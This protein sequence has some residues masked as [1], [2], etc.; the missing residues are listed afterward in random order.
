MKL[1]TRPVVVAV[2]GVIV[3]IAAAWFLFRP[4][5]EETCFDRLGGPG[6]N[7]NTS[8]LDTFIDIPVGQWPEV[9]QILEQF[10]TER[11]WSVQE[12][13][14]NTDPDYHW[15]DM[16]DAGVT[17]VRASNEQGEPPNQVGFGIIHMA[18]EGPARDGW[19]PYYR[20]L[21]RRL[22][23][24]WPGKLRYVEGE[25]GQTITRPLWLD[26]PGSAPAEAPAP[27]P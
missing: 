13:D 23:A 1:G 17:I 26:E 9:A 19:Q 25:F 8:R 14:G 18:Y 24:R 6:P 16:C 4:P 12:G 21:H 2:L 22:E 5:G 3:L 7:S 11:G 20:D 27:A 10:A 15:L